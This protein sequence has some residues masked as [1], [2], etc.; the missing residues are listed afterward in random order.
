MSGNK[1]HNTRAMNSN[2]ADTLGI[3]PL[4]DIKK[5][6]S[7]YDLKGVRRPQTGDTRTRPSQSN[8]GNM[9]GKSNKSPNKSLM[10]RGEQAYKG[11][12]GN[13]SNFFDFSGS[14][15]TNIDS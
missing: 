1:G 10:S 11:N 3:N 5:K 8:F 4:E 6:L 15:T 13:N 7:F 12:N 9:H 2:N 14:R